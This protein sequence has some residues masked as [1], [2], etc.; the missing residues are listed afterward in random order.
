MVETPIMSTTGRRNVI[1]TFLIPNSH[2]TDVIVQVSA[3]GMYAELSLR[4]P[5][6]FLYLVERFAQEVGANH[7]D[8][9]V[10]MAAL[11]DAENLML[12]EHPDRSNIRTSVQRRRLPFA[13]IQ[14]P[15]IYFINKSLN[16]LSQT[17]L[18]IQLG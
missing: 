9:P 1:G 6:M 10:I 3:D 11:R 14:N 15:I 2:E 8:A 4:V 13:C 18:L 17:L 5:P 12:H 16:K 7:P